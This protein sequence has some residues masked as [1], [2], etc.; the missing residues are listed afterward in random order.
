MKSQVLR[1]TVVANYQNLFDELLND[2]T[3]DKA[4]IAKHP[5]PRILP[6]RGFWRG[7]R[8]NLALF[9]I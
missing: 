5:Y 9:R 7:E 1:A 2:V 6:T 3:P 8:L 4:L